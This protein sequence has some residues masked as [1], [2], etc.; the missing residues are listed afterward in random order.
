LTEHETENAEVIVNRLIIP[1]TEAEK[2]VAEAGEAYLRDCPCRVQMK[3]CPR[4]EWE[5]CLLFTHASEEDRQ[6]AKRITVDQAL[7]IVKQTTARGQIHQVFYFQEGDRPFELCNC[8]T[9]CCFPLREE[10]AKGDLFKDQL[11]SDYFA[12][13][14]PASCIGCGDCISSCFFGARQLEGEGIELIDHLCFGCGV[15]L[16]ACPQDAI[17]LLDQPGRGIPVPKI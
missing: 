10:K 2:L 4:E 6:G 3:L 14:D 1:P 7:Q 9:C 5:V 15:C 12:E 16:T 11:R 17:Q 8:C 13:T